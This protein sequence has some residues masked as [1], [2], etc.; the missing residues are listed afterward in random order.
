MKGED[1]IVDL[2]NEVLTGELTAVNQYFLDAKMSAN[3]GYDRLASH[4]R[5]ESI[6]EMKDADALI[7]RIL[8][9]EGLP[10]LQRLGVVRVGETV[11]E[12]IT[13]A[14]DL[15]REAIERLN[16]GIGLCL[17]RSD[18]GTRRAPRA[19]PRGRGRSRRLA[20]DAAR[21]HPPDRRGA[22][23]RAAGARL[24]AAE[25]RWDPPGEGVWWL[26]R[27]HFPVPVS[28][29]FAELFPPSTVGWVTGAKRYGLPITS[30][31]FAAVNGWLY[32]SSGPDDSLPL[33]E[34]ERT[35]AH[36]LDTAAWRQEV[37][38]WF[39][40]ERPPVL[41]ANLALQT[42]DLAGADHRELADHIR[43]A[44][45][46]FRAVSPL[47]F[48]H[49]GFD[50]AGGRLF[51]AANEWGIPAEQRRGVARRRISRDGS[52]RRPRRPDCQCPDHST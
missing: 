51:R 48:E 12:Q 3:W 16:N 50:I 34:Q 40:E 42:E 32:Y 22:L 45:A 33:A 25:L 6:D 20:R 47:H 49:A 19:H 4:F 26:T 29:L 28:G 5:E 41:A 35:A 43:R 11:P 7:E 23:P 10:N 21:A 39:D 2:L 52:G 27:E 18:G 17:E 9:L 44:I 24:S 38:R 30:P 8:Y 15:E 37:T 31:R 36:T 1:A 13:L 14:L 46:H